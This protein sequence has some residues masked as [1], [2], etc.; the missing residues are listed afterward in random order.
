MKID[1]TKL[2]S[3]YKAEVEKICETF[4]WKTNFGQEEIVAIICRILENN[5]ELIRVEIGKGQSDNHKYYADLETCR[6]AQVRL[7]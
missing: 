1:T 4:D 3:L 2:L 6:T 5:P 7:I